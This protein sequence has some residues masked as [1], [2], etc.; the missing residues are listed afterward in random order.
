[1]YIGCNWL[2]LEY[3]H[4]FESFFLIQSKFD[5]IKI[6]GRAAKAHPYP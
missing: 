3:P 2:S 6:N 1:M 5:L 4:D